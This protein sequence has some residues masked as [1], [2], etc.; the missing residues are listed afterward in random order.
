MPD[1]VG[2]MVSKLAVVHAFRQVASCTGMAGYT[3]ITGHSPRVTGAQMFAKAGIPE[4]RVQLFGRWG[5]TAV[6]RYL[7]EVHL[8][9]ATHSIAQEVVSAG[10]F[11][12]LKLHSANLVVGCTPTHKRHI[13]EHVTEEIIGVQPLV[14]DSCS[15]KEVASSDRLD[16]IIRAV[17][18]MKAEIGAVETQTLPFAVRC[19]L[20][21]RLHVVSCSSFTQ[22]GWRWG[23][24][25]RSHRPAT[26]QAVGAWC[27]TCARRADRLKVVVDCKP[28]EG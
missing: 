15:T 8:E 6:R 20:S 5:S 16:I 10:D 21:G 19:K 11:A 26:D 3:G 7:R 23:G 12:D 22:C 9:A 24:D 14:A 27:K 13:I 17:Q 25:V 18:K 2:R 4:W 28:A 1:R